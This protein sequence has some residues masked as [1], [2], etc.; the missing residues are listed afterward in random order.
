MTPK[1]KAVVVLAPE[2]EYGFDDVGENQYP[3][4]RHNSDGCRRKSYHT[5]DI[6]TGYCVTCNRFDSRR[7][8]K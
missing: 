1:R 7:K 3:W 6:K 4:V 2:W 5:K 8:G